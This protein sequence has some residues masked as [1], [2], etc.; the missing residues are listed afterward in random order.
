VTGVSIPGSCRHFVVMAILVKSSI[1][2]R[3]YRANCAGIAD[4]EEEEN[5]KLASRLPAGKY[6]STCD[7][8]M[9]FIG[10]VEVRRCSGRFLSLRVAG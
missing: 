3:L 10:C 4:D 5:D 7:E 9:F 2:H 1:I 8:R 6:Q